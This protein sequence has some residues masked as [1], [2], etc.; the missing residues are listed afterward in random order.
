MKGK[1]GRTLSEFQ[2]RK[3][4][5]KIGGNRKYK[6]QAKGEKNGS[7]K[8]T[9]EQVNILRKKFRDFKPLRRETARILGILFHIS[10]RQ[11]YKIRAGKAWRPI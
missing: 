1:D 3:W 5:V 6:N 8:L 11:V 7:A 9:R 2:E 10:A 4:M